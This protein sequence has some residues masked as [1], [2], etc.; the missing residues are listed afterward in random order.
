MTVAEVMLYNMHYACLKPE[1]LGRLYFHGLSDLFRSFKAYS[2][3]LI[4]EN[5]RIDA[6]HLNGIR[7]VK[8]VDFQAF[9]SR[10]TETLKSDHDL[11]NGKLL[12]KRLAKLLGLCKRNA[13]NKRK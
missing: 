8:T 7:P 12:V 9:G 11:T 2:Y 4:A 13:V 10:Q 5:I 6:D 1:F 3:A